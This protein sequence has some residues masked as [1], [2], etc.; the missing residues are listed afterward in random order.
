MMVER[1]FSDR[2]NRWTTIDKKKAADLHSY[3][4]E[5][6]EKEIAQAIDGIDLVDYGCCIECDPIVSYRWSEL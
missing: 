4:L 5:E 3:Y 2:I 6:Y 1:M